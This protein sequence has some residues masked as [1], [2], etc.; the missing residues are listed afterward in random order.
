VRFNSQELKARHADVYAALHEGADVVASAPGVFFWAGE[1][2]VLSGAL[3]V[4]Q[5]VP[6]RVYVGLELVSR[7]RG[8]IRVDVDDSSGAHVMYDA[9]SD[10]FRPLTWVAGNPG[11]ENVA[12]RA[13]GLREDFHTVVVR[14][15]TSLG[16]TG[17]YR[18]R[19]LHELRR[20]AGSNW[21]GAF[22]SALVGALYGAAGRLA[23]HDTWTSPWWND[24][25][26]HE[27]HASAWELERI[28]HGGFASGYGTMCSMARCEVPQV[29]A[30][31]W[32]DSHDS[33]RDPRSIAADV[34]LATRLR[35]ASRPIVPEMPWERPPFDYGLIYTGVSKNT[36][37]AIRSTE[38][39]FAK[40]L[41]S[42]AALAVDAWPLPD[43]RP[44]NLENGPLYSWWRDRGA[45][46][47]EDDPVLQRLTLEALGASG[48]LVL[49]GLLGISDAPGAYSR[50]LEDL[51]RAVEAVAGG[52]RQL[53]L[54]RPEVDLV[55]AA[56]RW[57]HLARA[58][59][60]A[61]KPTGGGTG[62]HVLMLSPEMQ[63]RDEDGGAVAG[64]ASA[65][66]L[67]ELQSVAERTGREGV[68]L[69]WCR[70]RDGL[71]GKG[72][73]V[74]MRASRRSR[75][76]G[77]R[78]PV[79]ATGDIFICYRQEDSRTYVGRLCS[80]L[81]QH[82]IRY[83]RDI[84]N[85]APGARFRTVC[86]SAI[87]Q[88][89]TELVVIGPQWL[90]DAAGRRR[91]EDEHDMVRTEIETGLKLGK[92]LVPILV[93]GARMPAAHDLPASIHGLVELNA[94]ALSDEWWDEGIVRLI[95]ACSATGG[96]GE[97]AH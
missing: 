71:G 93:G 33:G 22:A 36:A 84:Q 73:L 64:T 78:G 27:C 9:K 92:P 31:Q 44:Y 48:L 24:P 55:R 32:R 65:H 43:G 46:Y 52:I 23:A 57:A 74:E 35:S 95:S 6:L 12:I 19:S 86:T 1:H 14:V 58:E 60:V 51:A 7:N 47:G 37:S 25:L 54:G 61:V 45:P 18:L 5:Q 67:D 16:L 59:Q 40:T 94:L 79:G 89:R 96:R 39:T 69:D 85:I 4:C 81:A 63:W 34:P 41:R 49:D 90:S 2:A 50:T 26:L 76:R 66:L 72:L 8:G 17:H 10:S 70:G 82:R 3:A 28:F 30:I 80:S 97:I 13:D 15:S 53:G 87:T 38:S 42:G 88:C 77:A 75:G 62:G 21:S 29:F 68:Q 83:F 91:I 56:V 11:E 20:G